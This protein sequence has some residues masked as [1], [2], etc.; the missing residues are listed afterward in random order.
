MLIR[1]GIENQ[2]EENKQKENRNSWE[3]AT[4]SRRIL[5]GILRG[6]PFG[7]EALEKL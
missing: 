6:N 1:D 5:I 4:M 2:N 3:Q 7:W